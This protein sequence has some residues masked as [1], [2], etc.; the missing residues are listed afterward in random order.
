MPN[1][2]CAMF[3]N[4]FETTR[5]KIAR[6]SLFW[7]EVV[8]HRHTNTP[9]PCLEMWQQSENKNR[10]KRWTHF[11]RGVMHFKP[12]MPRTHTQGIPATTPVSKARMVKFNAHCT[13]LLLLSCQNQ[14]S[15]GKI[16][17]IAR[18]CLK[19]STGDLWKCLKPGP[20][21]MWGFDSKCRTVT[22]TVNGNEPCRCHDW[23]WRW[24]T[25]E[26]NIYI[27]IYMYLCC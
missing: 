3:S 27:Y 12:E 25:A 17:K 2:V 16:G 7:L 15:H 4:I 13:L 20:V 26:I 5:L 21:K 8:C 9:T 19:M 10:Q 24:Q 23:I 22:R 6:I 11:L 18:A 14:Q 1:F